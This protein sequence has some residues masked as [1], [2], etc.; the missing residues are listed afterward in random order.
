VVPTT[1]GG[2]AGLPAGKTLNPVGPVVEVAAPVFLFQNTPK[3]ESVPKSAQKL[4]DP[5]QDIE[6]AGVVPE[7]V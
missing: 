3:A 2:I 1:S 4:P 7:H 5:V 6:I